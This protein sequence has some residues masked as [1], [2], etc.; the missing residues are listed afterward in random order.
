MK[1][2]NMNFSIKTVNRALKPRAKKY[3]IIKSLQKGQSARK[4]NIQA[5]GVKKC[6]NMKIASKG[7]KC[8]EGEVFYEVECTLMVLDRSKKRA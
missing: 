6:Q 5:K 2:L 8:K 3:Q 1:F 4:A 7:T